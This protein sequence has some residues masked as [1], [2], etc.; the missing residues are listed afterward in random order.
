MTNKEAVMAFY[1][2]ALTVNST[3]R[4]TAVLTQLAGLR[5]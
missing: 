1:E 3:T 4:P 2:Q 5:C